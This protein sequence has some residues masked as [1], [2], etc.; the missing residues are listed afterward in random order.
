MKILKKTIQFIFLIAVIGFLVRGWIYRHSVIYRTISPRTNYSAHNPKLIT[1]LDRKTKDKKLEDIQSIIDECLS[2]TS[3]QLYFSSKSKVVDPNKLI[4]SKAT[5]CVGYASFFATT[6]NYL[7]QK[8][9]L[10]NEWNAQPQA[11]QL[12]LFGHNI[13]QYFDSPF[14]KNHDFV[15]VKNKKTGTILAVDPS[16]YDY[17]FIKFVTYKL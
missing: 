10:N 8:S 1:N 12:Y 9:Q 3:D 13:H 11:G 5:H 16:L 7:L 4:D 14:F 15:I 2:I 17:L 6:C